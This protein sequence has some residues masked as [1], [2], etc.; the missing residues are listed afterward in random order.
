MSPT[1]PTC[2]IKLSARSPNVSL[3]FSMLR[4]AAGG[5]ARI[6]SRGGT[7]IGVV[8]AGTGRIGE[9]ELRPHAAFSLER[10]EGAVLT[11]VE[12]IEL[13]LAGCDLRADGSAVDGIGSLGKD[14]LWPRGTDDG[15]IGQR[16]YWSALVAVACLSTPRRAEPIEEFYRGKKLTFL[17]GENVAAAMTPIAGCSP[18]MSAPYS[19]QSGRGSAKHAG[20]GGLGGGNFL[21]V[22]A[23]KDGTVIGMIDQGLYLEQVLG[24]PG[25]EY[26]FAKF[27]WIGRLLRVTGVLVAWNSSPVKTAEDLKKH[28]LTV[29]ATG[30][31]SRQNWRILNG[32]VGARLKIIAGYTGTSGSALAMERGEIEGMSFPLVVLNSTRKAWVDERK[33]NILLQTGLERDPAIPQVPRM[34]DLAPTPMR[35]ASCGCSRLPIRSAVLS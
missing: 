21:Y 23:P 12:E 5:S 10:N 22:H 32:L 2:S 7:Q 26:D 31:S 15:D 14:P 6:A 16:R 29:S 25:I 34:I 1:N 11:A 24:R 27:N 8:I 18:V 17:I 35:S 9:D 4:V 13:L 19:R 3:I 33:V 20:W 30:A 28:E